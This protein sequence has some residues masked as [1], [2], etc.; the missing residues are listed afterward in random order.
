MN[1]IASVI[2]PVKNRFDL[3]ERA[4]SSIRRCNG[5][6]FVEVIVIDDGSDVPL[7]N[8]KNVDV[9]LRNESSLGAAVS[10]NQGLKVAKGNLIYLLDSDDYFVEKDF[11]NE[12]EIAMGS[13]AVWYSD[14]KSQSYKSD[15]PSELNKFNFFESIFYRY[16]HI[17][18]T[19]SL[20]FE[21][22]LNLRFDETLPKHQDWDFIYFQCLVNNIEVKSGAGTIYFDRS[23]QQSISRKFIPSRSLPWFSKIEKYLLENSSSLTIDDIHFY[24]FSNSN[25][26]YSNFTFLKRMADLFLASNI[27]V[28]KALRI[29]ARR[30]LNNK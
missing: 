26:H 18:Q 21:K 13:S 7:A 24:L 6:E 20:Y 19:S 30:V 5:A 16:P 8:N 25:Q 3:L 22:S 29:F 15:F 2:I 12:C 1:Y 27:S 23:D 17:C 10:R 11:L 4:V 14:V 9:V 28:D